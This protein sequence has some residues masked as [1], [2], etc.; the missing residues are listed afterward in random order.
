MR[1]II[2]SIGIASL[3]TIIFL[4]AL[5]GY[6]GVQANGNISTNSFP[7]NSQPDKEKEI[8]TFLES[9]TASFNK[10]DA[11]A[12]GTLFLP[13][14]EL[15]DEDGNVLKTREAI[16]THYSDIFKTKPESRLK[17]EDKTIRLI[18]DSLAMYDGLA[19]VKPSAQETVRRTR[20]A[21]VL[22]KQGNQWQIA[23]IRDL[24]DLENNSGLIWESMAE[25]GFLVGEWLEEGGN[26]RIQTDCQWSDDKMSLIQKFKISG[27]GI[28][29]LS[30]TQRIGWDPAT[31]KIKSW[32]HDTQG[33]YAEALWTKS[34]ASW[35]VKSNGTNSDGDATSMTSVYQAAGNGRI[36]IYFRDRIIGDEVLPDVNTTIVRK[37]PEAKP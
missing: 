18:G 1:K 2:T 37:P 23:S 13:E 31:Q 24:E 9:V 16:E 10:H 22:I 14:G 28:K 27:T 6:V 12:V 33:G 25:L 3:G 32:T 19:E 8:R 7:L 35:F 21:A 34:G 17:V 11:K 36:D 29:E 30:G 15:V 26:F 20:F 4:V 5:A